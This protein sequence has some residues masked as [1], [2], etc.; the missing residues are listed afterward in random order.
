MS[1]ATAHSDHA[2]DILGTIL[3][4]WWLLLIFGGGILEWIAETFDVGLTALRRRAKVKH[5]RRMELERLKVR[6]A[7]AQGR[8]A[9]LLPPAAQAKAP[10]PCVHRNVTA[11]VAADD[12]LVGWLC[13]SCDKRLEPDWAV[14]EEDL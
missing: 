7:E 14:R 12:S 2:A 13:K 6:L 9:V 1:A 4:Y 5:K 3:S 10:G 8:P 11:I